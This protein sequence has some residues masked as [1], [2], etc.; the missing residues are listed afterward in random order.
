MSDYLGTGYTTHTHDYQ[1]TGNY[2]TTAMASNAGSDFVNTS[3][4]SLFQ[5]TANNSLSLGTDYTSH[6]HS[7]YV[8][9]S[10]SSNFLT[11]QSDQA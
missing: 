10:V 6:T 7:Q 3:Q 5:L 9:T 2:L 4:S 11:S 1:T 8:N